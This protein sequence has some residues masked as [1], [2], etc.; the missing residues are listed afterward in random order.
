MPRTLA[1]L[2]TLALLIAAC[3]TGEDPTAED[4]AD[5]DAADDTATDEEA[6]SDED[7]A[8]ELTVG[9]E[10]DTYVQEG[11]GANVGM[12]PLNTNVYETLIRVTPEYDLEPMLAED[13]EFVEPNTWRFHLRDDV[14]FHNG[15]PMDAEAVKEGL[16]DRVAADGG[17]TIR[18]GEDSAEVVDEHTIDFTPTEE[19]MRVPEQIV[20]PNNSVVAPGTMPDGEELVGTGPFRFVEYA[21]DEQISVERNPD[22][23]GEEP[24]LESITFRFF[25]EASSRMRALEAGEID[26]AV[27]VPR[28]E[29]EA[30]ESA[31]L[32]IATSEVG[33]YRAIYSNIHGEEPYDLLGEDAVRHA[34]ARAINREEIVEE[35]LNGLATTD[36]TMIPPRLLGEHADLIEG[37]EHDPD[38]A[39][40]LLEDAGWEEG[41][42]GIRERDG[43]RLELS[44]ESGFGGAEVHRPVPTVLESQLA[45]VGIAL[46]VNEHPDSASYQEVIETGEGD[47]FLEQGSQNDANPGFL[48]VLLFYSQGEAADAPYQSL[49][50]P[51]DEFDELIEPNLTSPEVDDSLEAV[52]EAMHV[53]IDEEAIVLPFAGIYRV[54]GHDPAVQ[55]FD[56]HPSMLNLRWSKISMGG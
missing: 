47:L 1:V 51:G 30:L 21:S 55:N 53:L 49:F 44:L 19:N 18:A 9:A 28:E 11:E 50:A 39:I 54:V 36:Q 32:E 34:V 33:A 48:P 6:G 27:E 38:E 12:Y 24:A 56:P 16:F 42:D 45:E 14:T 7:V 20:H 40:E 35:V 29:A 26:I 5:D 13:W 46:D 31:G 2:L 43:R 15:E 3:T 17:G 10:D 8:Q 4:T 41:D 22:Y 37:F 25:P 52:A 23:W